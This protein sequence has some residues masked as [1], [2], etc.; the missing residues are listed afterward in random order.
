MLSAIRPPAAFIPQ[1]NNSESF[2]ANS[3]PRYDSSL[4]PTPGDG[5][6]GRSNNQGFEGLTMNPSGT[7]LY[8]LLQSALNQDGNPKSATS[9]NTR[10]IAYDLTVSPPAAVAEYVV[11]LNHVNASDSSSK[12]ARQSEMHYVSD[13]Q[14]LVLARDS[15][16]GRG[17]GSSTTSIYRHVDVFDIS[18]ATNILGKSDCTTCSVASSKGVLNKNTTAAAYCSWLDFNVNSQLNR[19]GVH[20]G[21]AQDATLLNEKWESLALLPVNGSTTNEYFLF[22]M[23]DNDFITQNGSLKGG[24]FTY[25][26]NSGYN[27]DSQVLVFKVQLP[28]G[29]SPLVA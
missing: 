27:I 1:R 17:Q 14:F 8:A 26:D 10:L 25:A 4:A 12:T 11:A 3:P 18:N 15:G 9:F 20:N 16:A 13:T 24:A 19:F 28:S 7:R 29:A 22:T 23:S 6:S 21:G 2:S 5:P